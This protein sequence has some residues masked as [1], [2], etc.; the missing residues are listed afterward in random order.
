[1]LL[2]WALQEELPV[3]PKSVRPDRIAENAAVF[4]WQLAPEDMQRLAALDC[5]TKMAWDP[6][7]VA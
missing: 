2:R 7:V 4:D 3:L 1:M 5:G 6:S